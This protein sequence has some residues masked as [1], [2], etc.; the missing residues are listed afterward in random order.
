MQ[1]QACV[2]YFKGFA[3]RLQCSVSQSLKDIRKRASHFGMMM[4]R[5]ASHALAQAL[6]QELQIR[7]G[8][9]REKVKENHTHGLAGL[10]RQR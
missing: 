10:L 7:H 2:S 1:P 5:F 6:Q 9:Y 4:Y 8:L 3:D